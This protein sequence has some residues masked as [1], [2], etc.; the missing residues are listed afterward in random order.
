MSDASTEDFPSAATFGQE[1][2]AA[3]STQPCQSARLDLIFHMSPFLITC[4]LV[5]QLFSSCLW[6]LK[7]VSFCI[8]LSVLQ[9]ARRFHV[10][11]DLG[12]PNATQ[13][14]L[15][16]DSAT[17]AKPSVVGL[18]S[19][20]LGLSDAHPF[21]STFAGEL[22]GWHQ[23]LSRRRICG[24]L[25]LG[26]KRCTSK[27]KG[28]DDWHGCP[29]HIATVPCTH[30]MKPDL[31]L[32]QRWHEST[33]CF[34]WFV[35]QALHSQLTTLLHSI[36]VFVLL[37]FSEVQDG[38]TWELCRLSTTFSPRAAVTPIQSFSPNQ[39]NRH[40]RSEQP[41]KQSIYLLSQINGDMLDGKQGQ[42]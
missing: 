24:R 40:F 10:G 29:K 31:A 1:V 18:A 25:H 39:P 14:Q 9:K 5:D 16:R 27:R 30:S 3:F 11:L 42:L 13:N 35:A 26:S 4:I 37:T 23:Y 15:V 6:L 8:V 20:S 2:G 7:V 38:S 36:G 28:S 34:K 17:A 21:V 12:L 33:R 41:M 32:Q 22:G 19:A